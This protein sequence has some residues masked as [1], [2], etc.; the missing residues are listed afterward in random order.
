M[1]NGGHS[2]CIF[3]GEHI[4]LS[5]KTGSSYKQSVISRA[6]ICSLYKVRG[7]ELKNDGVAKV[8]VVFT[9][10]ELNYLLIGLFHDLVCPLSY[11]F[12]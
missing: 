10:T 8:V 11:L 3:N 7:N 9:I 6:I 5:F 4:T 12:L 2:P 1:V